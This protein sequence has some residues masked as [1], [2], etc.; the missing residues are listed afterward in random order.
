[1]KGSN[2]MKTF[3]ALLGTVVVTYVVAQTYN[4]RVTDND[5]KEIYCSP[6]YKKTNRNKREDEEYGY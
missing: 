2:T 4:I 3:I 6:N 5:G 1:M